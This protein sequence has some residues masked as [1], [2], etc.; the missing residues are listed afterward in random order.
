MSTASSIRSGY[1]DTCF[2]HVPMTEILRP[3]EKLKENLLAAT[4]EVD[5]I[6]WELDVESSPDHVQ[7]LAGRLVTIQDFNNALADYIVKKVNDWEKYQSNKEFP[8]PEEYRRS[9]PRGD[10]SHDKTMAEFQRNKAWE[11]VYQV[12]ALG[13]FSEQLSKKIT[14][15]FQKAPLVEFQWLC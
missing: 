8:S 9:N 6:D 10:Y 2:S 11:E 7:Y 3:S 5:N 14:R 15:V 1:C 13:T 12:K 4:F